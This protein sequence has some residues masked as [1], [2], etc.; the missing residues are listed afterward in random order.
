[1]ARPGGVSLHRGGAGEGGDL[2]RAAEACSYRGGRV[3][4]VVTELV[5]VLVVVELVVVEEGG[6]RWMPGPGDDGAGGGG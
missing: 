3:V 5:V 4:L 6:I 1:M 2:C